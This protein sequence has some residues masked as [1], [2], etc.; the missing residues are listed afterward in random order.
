[1]AAFALRRGCL[2]IHVL[3]RPLKVRRPVAVDACRGTVSSLK[4]EGGGSMVETREFFPRLDG[5]ASLALNAR[6]C[7]LH[8]FLKLSAMGIGM[9]GRAGK[10]VPMIGNG[11]FRL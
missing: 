10:V 7:L 2:E 1:M 4:G 8:P 6:T 11:G 9:A 5:V 3:Q